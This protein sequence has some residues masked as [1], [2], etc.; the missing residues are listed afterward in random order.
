MMTIY[1]MN[2]GQIIESEQRKISCEEA[3][4]P[5]QERR[6]ELSLQYVVPSCQSRTEKRLP[7]ELSSLKLDDFLQRMV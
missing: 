3:C 2:T 6:V 5:E 1:D 4:I 7:P